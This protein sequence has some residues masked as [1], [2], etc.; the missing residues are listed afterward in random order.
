MDWPNIVATLQLLSGLAWLVPAIYLTPRIVRSWQR[1]ASRATALAAPIGFLCW[2]MVGFS[3]R[4][5]IWP[6][7][8]DDM[9][10]AELVAWSALYALSGFLAAWFLSGARQ[11]R[12][13]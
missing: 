1:G 7:A 6:H 2:L 12:G 9:T 11:T 10:S 5:L 13:E 4:W 8:I 3:I